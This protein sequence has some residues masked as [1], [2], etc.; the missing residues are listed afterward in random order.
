MKPHL[1]LATS[2][3]ILAPYGKNT[4]D[5]DP[6][7]TKDFTNGIFVASESYASYGAKR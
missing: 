4:N 7:S 5:G 1:N 3:K 2:D 6:F